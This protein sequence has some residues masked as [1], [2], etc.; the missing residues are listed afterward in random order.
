MIIFVSA[1]LALYLFIGINLAIAF[2]KMEKLNLKHK[3]SNPSELIEQ[4]LQ[5]V[6]A[7]SGF[8]RF[9]H[10]NKVVST[11]VNVLFWPMNMRIKLK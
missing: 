6:K 9:I 3:E 8:A 1:V 2:R 10:K 4:H 11:L 7:K 5:V